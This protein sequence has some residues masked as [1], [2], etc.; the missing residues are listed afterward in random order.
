MGTAMNKKYIVRLTPEDRQTLESLVR[1]GRVAA[2]K[3]K[4]AWILLQADASAHG[5]GWSDEQIVEAYGVG[6]RTVHRVRQTWVEEGLAA[7]LSRATQKRCRSRKL[8]GEQEAHL[9]AL[10]CSQP[11]T[12][13]RRWTIRLL[14]QRFVALGHCSAVSP[15]TIR[16]T[17]KKTNSS[18]IW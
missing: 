18:R 1:R 15:E 4:R 3:A 13:R 14:A 6:S 17:L 10:A 12:G 8:D 9:I 5:P 7:V 11:P 16:Q 2:Y